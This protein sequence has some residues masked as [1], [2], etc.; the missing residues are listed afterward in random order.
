MYKGIY[1][2]LIT[3][4]KSDLSVDYET[5]RNLVKFHI[6]SKTKGIVV[7]GTTA[8]TATLSNEEYKKILKFVIDV[9][10]EERSDIDLIAGTGSNSTKKTIENTKLAESLGYKAA[11]VVTPYYNKPSQRGLYEHFKCVA[12]NT[13]ID[14]ILYD[15]PSRTGTKIDNNVIKELSKIDN[16]KAI[17]DA[18]GNILN[19]YE[20]KKNTNL[21]ILSG[22]DGIYYEQLSVGAVG[23]ISV[24]ANIYPD[25][26]Q[27]MTDLFFEGKIDLS[28][29]IFEKIYPIATN[30]FIEGNPVTVKAYMFLKGMIPNMKVRLPLVEASEETLEKLRE[31][32]I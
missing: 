31:V 1:V 29:K 27:E 2:A 13:T 20:H 22:E 16:I 19:I 26:L 6:E 9:V 15:I 24:V 32:I 18:T 4:F 10:S 28:F 21:D 3:P 14:I 17:K 11:L 7:C 25:L 12:E 5:L 30:L 8:E 23:T